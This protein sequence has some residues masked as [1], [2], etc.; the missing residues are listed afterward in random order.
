MKEGLFMTKNQMKIIYI[1]LLICSLL[2][3][4]RI[5]F[6][7]KDGTNDI[8]EAILIALIFIDS[9]FILLYFIAMKLYFN[10]SIIK[11]NKDK[12]IFASSIIIIELLFKINNYPELSLTYLFGLLLGVVLLT[13]FSSLLPNKGSRIFDVAFLIL[14]TFYVLFQDF[15]HSLFVDMF[16]FKEVVTIREGAEFA[17][18]VYRFSVFHV[19]Y[20]IVLV[21][22]L[23]L[24][25]SNKSTT[26]IK[27]SK[28]TAFTLLQLPLLLFV[29]LNLNA[30]YPVK[31]ARLHTSDHYLYYSNFDKQK[32]TSRFSL[33]SLFYR[34]IADII[35]PNLSASKDIEYIEDY[36]LNNVKTHEDNEFTNMFEGKNLIFVLAESFDEI[37]VS[38]ELTPTLF[39][40]KTEGIDFQNHYTPVYPRTTCDTEI[41]M[42]T[43]LIPSITDGPTCYMFNKNKYNNSLANLFNNK[44]YTSTA[45]HS[46]NRSFYTREIVYQGLGYDEFLGQED[47]G[48]S[49]TEKRY[50]SVFASDTSDFYIKEQSPFFSFMISLSGHSPYNMDHLAVSKHISEVEDYYGDSLPQSVKYFIAAQMEADIMMENILKELEEKDELDNTVII[51][52]NDHYPYTLNQD[53]FELV[54]GTTDIHEKQQGAMYIWTPGIE[55]KQVSTL[56]SSFDILPTI[57]AIFGLDIDYTN[58]IG[59]DVFD[60]SKSQYVYFKDYTVFNG[61]IFIDISSSDVIDEE[62]CYK[63]QCRYD[64]SKKILKTNYF[65]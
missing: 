13:M 25:F 60:T 31:S 65:E 47:L 48:L 59:N 52:T 62:L 23:K 29:L 45:L 8:V 39:K 6:F 14:Y 34:D 28:K 17:A 4:I 7:L 51:F 63:A 20:F 15:Y 38:E 61:E 53:D 30:T 12:I 50:D 54:K 42:N 32:V 24:Y 1:N 9:L 64:L 37:A 35:S 55:A 10:K 21:V 26:R 18:G 49:D 58:Y 44:G 56:S 36:F 22:A 41:I 57:A 2:L 40:L 46:N 11:N 19:L 27:F 33:I 43:G 5:I 3:G 16:S